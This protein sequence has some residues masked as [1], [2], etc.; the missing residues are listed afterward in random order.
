ME[1]GVDSTVPTGCSVI[2]KM[3]EPKV[4]APLEV[5]P[6]D[7]IVNGTA[8]EPAAGAEKVK[9]VAAVVPNAVTPAGKVTEPAATKAAVAAVD[10]VGSIATATGAD[11]AA[12]VAGAAGAT[13]SLPPQAA[14]EAANTAAKANLVLVLFKI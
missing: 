3:Q 8:V 5:M 11:T 9:V 13:E 10:V 6:P 12:T 14:K 7:A 4:K 2:V 1:T